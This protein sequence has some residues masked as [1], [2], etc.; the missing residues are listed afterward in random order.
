MAPGSGSTGSGTGSCLWRCWLDRTPGLCEGRIVHSLSTLLPSPRHDAKSKWWSPIGPG[1]A[2]STGDHFM[3]DI[4][5]TVSQSFETF[6]GRVFLIL[7]TDDDSTTT[8]LID[9]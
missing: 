2:P 9:A 3:D 6:E 4:A 8:I 7:D 1:S 5:S